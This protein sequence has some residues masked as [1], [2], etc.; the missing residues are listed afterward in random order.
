MTRNYAKLHFVQ[1]LTTKL[2]IHKIVQ[3]EIQSYALNTLHRGQQHKHFIK[4]KQ[5]NNISLT[6]RN[7]TALHRL[8]LLLF[9]PQRN[10]APRTSMAVDLSNLKFP[11]HFSFY[12]TIL[13]MDIFS[14]NKPE[15][16]I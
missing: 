3:D 12:I 6:D 2:A 10:E 8:H 4:N 7:V 11:G 9:C 13:L 1:N 14:K 15:T 5:I 16:T